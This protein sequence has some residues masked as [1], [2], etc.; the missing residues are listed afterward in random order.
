[1]L[2]IVPP[3]PVNYAAM[4]KSELIDIIETQL[5]AIGHYQYRHVLDSAAKFGSNGNLRN[6]IYHARE[7][8]R[9]HKPMKDGPYAGLYCWPMK[10]LAAAYGCKPS[11]AGDQAALL[12]KSGLCDYEVDRDY[13]TKDGE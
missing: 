9:L 11:N 12:K 10:E 3:Q 5:L 7:Y 13:I 6:F 4:S 1:M 2:A 8:E